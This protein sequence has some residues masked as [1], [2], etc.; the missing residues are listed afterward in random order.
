MRNTD[1]VQALADTVLRIERSATLGTMKAAVRA[2]ATPLGYDRFVLYAAGNAR[3]VVRD[4]Y[5]IEGDWFGH[6]PEL[7]ARRYLKRCPVNHHLFETDRAFFWTKRDIEGQETYRLTDTPHGPGLHG[8]QVP[9]FGPR[10]LAAA[11]SFGGRVI[12]HSMVARL[13]LTLVAQAAYRMAAASPA[14]TGHGQTLALSAREIQVLRWIA[15]GKRQADVAALLGLSTRTIENHL[16]RV[17]ERLGVSTT[18]EAVR[19]AR[20]AGDLDA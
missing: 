18:T 1:P 12:D 17:R 15:A 10:G 13:S 11:M 5:W 2:F 6:G 7:D 20:Q 9:I 19:A 16:R 4:L 8:L 14:A 3:M